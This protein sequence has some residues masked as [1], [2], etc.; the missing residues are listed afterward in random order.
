MENEH[1]KFNL[2]PLPYSYN[3]LEPHIDTLTMQLHHDRHLKTYVDNLNIALEKYPEYQTWSLEKLIKNANWLPED[4][5]TD[6]KHNAG[7]VYNH[8]F[9]F[10]N[11][12]GN[13]NTKLSEPLQNKIKDT[14]GSFEKLKRN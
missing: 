10:K 2:V 11:M 13:K 12:T 9:F 4:I 5:R 7:G 8:N 1:Y 14:F 6:V 3:A